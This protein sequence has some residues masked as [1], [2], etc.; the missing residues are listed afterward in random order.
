MSR[1]GDTRS[2]S[3]S[4]V[5]AI[6]L[7]GSPW[8]AQAQPAAKAPPARTQRLDIPASSLAE[9]LMAFGVQSGLQVSFARETVAGL[10]SRGL[11]GDYA[12]AEALKAL[13]RGTNLGYSFINGSTV[14]IR[15]APT[16]PAPAEAPTG[17]LAGRVTSGGVP[18][19]GVTV[20]ATSLSLEVTRRATTGAEGDYSL[21]ALPAGLYSV[22]FELEGLVTEVK[23]ARVS[24]GQ[25]MTL[26]IQMSLKEVREHIVV[27]G[28]HIRSTGERPVGTNVITID[29]EE[30]ERSGLT[31]VQDVVRKLPQN[32]GGGV[33]EEFSNGREGDTNTVDGNS[34]NLRGLGSGA[35]LVLLNGRRLA[36]SGGEGI[37]TDITSIPL[38]AVE[39]IEVL[40]DGASAVYGADAVGGVVN[41]ILRKDYT[42][43]ET[44]LRAGTVTEGGAQEYQLGQSFGAGWSTGHGLLSYEF[45][46]RDALPRRARAL[47]ATCDLT[48]FGGENFCNMFSNPGNILVGDIFVGNLTTYAIPHG[49]DGTSLTPDDFTAGTVNFENPNPSQ[50]LLPL[51]R[52]HSLSG[53]VSQS[54]GD[55]LTLEGTALFSTRKASGRDAAPI[56]TLVVTDINPFYVN[57]AGGTEPILIPYSFQADFG[58]TIRETDIDTYS[59]ALTGKLKVTERW[60]LTTDVG[61]SRDEHDRL[62]DGVLNRDEF[63]VPLVFAAL[64]DPNPAT[65]FNPFGDGSHTNPDTVSRIRGTTSFSGTSDLWTAQAVAEGPVWRLPGGDMRL[66]VG[67]EYRRQEFSS[68]GRETTG[69]L[70]KAQYNRDLSAAFAELRVPLVGPTSLRPGVN[71][72]EVSLAGRYEKYGDFGDSTN[73][74]FGVE[75]SPVAG[76][77]FRGSWG[78]S[79]KAP[80]VL[81]LSETQNLSFIFPIPDPLAEAGFS[82][83]LIWTGGNADLKEETATVWNLGIEISPPAMPNLK[84]GLTYFDIDFKDRIELVL[85]PFSALLDPAFADVV[86]RTPTDEQREVACS[87]STFLGNPDDC[88]NM[89]IAA[90]VDGR[91]SNSAVV[92]NRGLDF[93]ASYRLESGIGAFTFNLNGTYLTKFARALRRTSPLLDNLNTP[94]NP[95]DLRLRSSVSWS[96]GG[97]E[98]TVYTNYTDSYRDTLSE[99]E[100]EIDSWT[101]FDLGLSYNLPMLGGTAVLLNV[102][103]VFDQGP[104]FYNNP[105][106][107]GYDPVNAALL[108]R[109]VSFQ[110]RKSWGRP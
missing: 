72:L 55:R 25:T 95:V 102:Q 101:T 57:P 83:A 92:R 60:L 82:D 99:P 19:A 41:I 14:V 46:K 73:P 86:T 89:P 109:F 1:A 78:T 104:P 34:L 80:A 7:L 84:L 44:R 67:A 6:A 71:R 36:P 88:R 50:D 58:S 85:D 103:N 15:S 62:I 77:S 45:Y 18:F 4:T 97:F 81:D 96:R 10:R 74:K 64:D 49:Q 69:A 32:L 37:F 91:I 22:R 5:V 35:T 98:G 8:M 33:N 54:A 94:L 28:T 17:A 23:E 52:R 61:Y 47:S 30:I 105:A 43:S 27:T 29:R 3:L 75:W 21:A 31:T 16:P 38:S 11:K 66:A 56:E 90:L 13:L 76:L 108:G 24:P 40:L 93:L 68:T 106:G 59:A 110:L 53:F 70:N 65:A 87:R 20:T 51:Q 2:R 79:F 12:P 39:R 9:A 63:F 26:D 48:R 42:G 100:R 107:F